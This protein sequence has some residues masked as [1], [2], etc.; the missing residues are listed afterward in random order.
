MLGGSRDDSSSSASTEGV[1]D[2]KEAFVVEFSLEGEGDR[3][4]SS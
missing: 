1:G 4:G 3:G 2:M